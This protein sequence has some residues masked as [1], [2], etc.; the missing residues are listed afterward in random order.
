MNGLIATFIAKSHPTS[1]YFIYYHNYLFDVHFCRSWMEEKLIYCAV[2][3]KFSLLCCGLLNAIQN[4]LILTHKT[5]PPHML[6]SL[7]A[8]APLFEEIHWRHH[9]W[10]GWDRGVGSGDPPPPPTSSLTFTQNAYKDNEDRRFWKPGEMG[11]ITH[12]CLLS[13]KLPWILL[14]YRFDQYRASFSQIF[15]N[16]RG[17]SELHY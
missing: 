9:G 16:K 11:M 10:V 6:I 12:F 15:A 1:R 5:D 2:M 7:V 4:R 17:Q 13:P 14:L 8:S 3:R